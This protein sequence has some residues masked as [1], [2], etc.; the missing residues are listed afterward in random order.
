MRKTKSFTANREIYTCI[1]KKVELYFRPL[2]NFATR[3]QVF[4]VLKFSSRNEAEKS[5]NGFL[6]RRHLIA[7]TSKSQSL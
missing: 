3:I 7:Q 2:N 5:T 1:I 6:Y 4:I